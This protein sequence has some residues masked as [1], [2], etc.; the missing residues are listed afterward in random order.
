M[1][2][3]GG[4]VILALSVVKYCQIVHR[5]ERVRMILTQHGCSLFQTLDVHQ[6]V[7]LVILELSV[8]KYCQTDHQLKRV[9]M[10]LTQCGL[11]LFQ[12]IYEQGVRLRSY[13]PCL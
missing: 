9:G 1:H 7:R 11:P 8:I 2:R 13:W 12:T 6:W 4:L 10:I 5:P 3:G